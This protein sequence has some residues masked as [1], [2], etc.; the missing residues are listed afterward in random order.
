M[1]HATLLSQ[2]CNDITGMA[3]THGIERSRAFAVWF[4]IRFFDLSEE[5]AL[6]AASIDGANDKGI[7]LFFR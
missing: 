5:E 2:V 7:D 4:A 3:E 6:D 1:D